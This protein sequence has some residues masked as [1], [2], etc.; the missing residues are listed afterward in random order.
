MPAKKS[1]SAA[2]RKRGRP[3]KAKARRKPASKGR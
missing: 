3:A 2:K 1:T